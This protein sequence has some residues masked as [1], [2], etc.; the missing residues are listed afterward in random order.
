MVDFQP[1]CTL[2][3]QSIDLSI[4]S[5]N[6]KHACSYVHTVVSTHTTTVL[7]NASQRKGQQKPKASIADVAI[8][9]AW[10]C[11]LI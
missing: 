8:T 5:G 3:Q 7:A 6:C 10:L 11:G 4:H 2:Q 9:K 1:Q